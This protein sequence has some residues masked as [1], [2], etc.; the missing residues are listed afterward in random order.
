MAIDVRPATT[1]DL[2]AVR[3]LLAH[4]Q[5]RPGDVAWSSATWGRIL[6]DP[7][8]TVLVAEDRGEFAVGTA[9]VLIVPNLTHDGTPWALVENV[10]VDPQWRRRGVGR[11][12]LKH[13]VRVADD[14]GC[15]KVQLTSS[16]HRDGAH[17]FYERLG[18]TATSTGFRWSFGE[19]ERAGAA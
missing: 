9:D 4:L 6:G 8:R 15:Y 10:V 12:L 1:G 14:A 3:T 16:N 17:R 13:A 2:A 11:A 7:N 5:D 18:F 19:R